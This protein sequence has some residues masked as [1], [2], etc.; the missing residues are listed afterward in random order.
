MIYPSEPKSDVYIM[1]LNSIP[2]PLKCE[3]NPERISSNRFADNEIEFFRIKKGISRMVF[4]M[5]KWGDEKNESK[6]SQNVGNSIHVLPE[7]CYP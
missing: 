7:L 1:D 5:L 2:H 4:Y 6:Q 3:A